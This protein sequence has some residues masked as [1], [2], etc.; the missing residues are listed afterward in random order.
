M[1]KLE[2]KTLELGPLNANCYLVWD[3]KTLEAIVID[4]ADAGGAISEEIL[5]EK[6]DLRKIILTHGH[7]DH[8]LGLLELKLNF[9]KAKISVHKKDLFLLETSQ[10]RTLHWLKRKTDPT[11]PPDE[12][13]DDKDNFKLGKIRFEIIHTPGH[14][15]GSICLYI[16]NEEILFSGDTLF[17][18]G[19]GRTDFSYSDPKKMK[20]SLEKI[21]KIPGETKVYSGH[22]ETTTIE[23]E[24]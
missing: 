16:K 12:F 13:L 8:I 17:S 20:I 10:Q 15:P 23:R 4:P 6:L 14:T 9:P 1:K 3:K 5:R 22:G 24:K 18:K 11:P 7:F 21:L 2:I 19:I